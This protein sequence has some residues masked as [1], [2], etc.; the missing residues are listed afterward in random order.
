MIIPLVPLPVD[1]VRRRGLLTLYLRLLRR[2]ALVPL[3]QRRGGAVFVDIALSLLLLLF[4]E[5]LL[6]LMF[7]TKLI[8]VLLLLLVV[9]LVVDQVQVV[10]VKGLDG[11]GLHQRVLRGGGGGGGGGDDAS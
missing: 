7:I 9:V 4:E 11:W 1:R 3:R 8:V 10:R 2:V 6:L 5:L